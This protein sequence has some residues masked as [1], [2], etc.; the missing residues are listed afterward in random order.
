M[1][2]WI[3][4]Q[5][6]E[7]FGFSK[8]ETNGTLVLLLLTSICL[9]AP[10]GLRWYHS[11]QSQSSHDLDVALLERTLALLETQVQKSKHTRKILKKNLDRSRLLRSFDIN[12]ANEAQLSTIEG[13]GQV[14]SSRIVK[15]RDK[16]G[17]FIDQAQY[18][19]VYGL[20]PKA[21][22]CLKKYAYISADFQAAKLDINTANAQEMAAHPY[23]TYR[24]A[25]SIV[26]YRAQ[27][28]SFHTVEALGSL[29]L[30]DEATFKK[31]NPY[32]CASQ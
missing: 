30:I 13:I 4:A 3:S 20:S 10:Q 7:Y 19:E 22:E 17:G 12:T 11:V 25:R 24:Q 18:Q 5:L 21:V 29:I 16:L 23:L 15:F 26:R 2:S 8:T 31:L 1:F 6:R 27:H 28:G 9:L 14:F 32:L